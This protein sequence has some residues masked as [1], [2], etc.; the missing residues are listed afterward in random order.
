MPLSYVSNK[1][2][3]ALTQRG[4]FGRIIRAYM[5]LTR[6][7]IHGVASCHFRC[8]SPLLLPL[9][10]RAIR[11]WLSPRLWPKGRLLSGGCRQ[12]C[13]PRRNIASCF[14]SWAAKQ[15]DER[16]TN[17]D[18]DYNRLSSIPQP[19]MSRK[20]NTSAANIVLISLMVFIPARKGTC[21]HSIKWWDELFRGG[22]R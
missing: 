14:S 17:E 18:L 15:F 3:H 2:A 21:R 11:R 13:C 12:W 1:W 4:F 6:A 19:T 22:R 16:D 9:S 10:P 7:Q 5:P 20:M 8:D